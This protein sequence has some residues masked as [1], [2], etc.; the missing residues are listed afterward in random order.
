MIDV[1]TFCEKSCSCINHS[2]WLNDFLSPAWPWL[3][4]SA[5]CSSFFP[6]HVPYSRLWEAAPLSAR[7]TF[8]FLWNCLTSTPTS[9]RFFLFFSIIGTIGTITSP[10]FMVPSPVWHPPPPF[11]VTVLFIKR[12]S[13]W[14]LSLARGFPFGRV[15]VN[16]VISLFRPPAHSPRPGETAVLTL[17]QSAAAG[18]RYQIN[19]ELSL[20]SGLR[21]PLR[22]CNTWTCGGRD[23]AHTHTHMEV[24]GE[25]CFRARMGSSIATKFTRPSEPRTGLYHISVCVSVYERERAGRQTWSSGC[26]VISL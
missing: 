16:K 7:E 1:W 15:S 9:R 17:A 26:C 23:N 13:H 10:L 12:L 6:C 5:R 2:V 21:Q 25:M 14:S 4:L 20:Q 8:S 18:H 19:Q 22:S 11:K 24:P 3:L